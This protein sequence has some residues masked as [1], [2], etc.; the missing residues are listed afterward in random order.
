MGNVITT[1][2]SYMFGTGPPAVQTNGMSASAEP[3]SNDTVWTCYRCTYAYNAV[4]SVECE[5]CQLPRIAEGDRIKVSSAEWQCPLCTLVNKTSTTT[6]T[7]CGKMT[8]T[9]I[10]PPASTI[11][12]APALAPARS[13]RPNA[14]AASSSNS[15]N[16]RRAPPKSDARTSDERI[17]GRL[18]RHQ[19]MLT[20]EKNWEVELATALEKY[21]SV[22][23]FCLQNREPV[24]IHRYI[25]PIRPLWV[26]YDIET[27]RTY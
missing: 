21:R 11:G 25:R 3:P 8:F 20:G 5:Q 17:L 15:A 16:G 14:A 22:V 19:N 27:L 12:P 18:D 9:A 13:Q 4:S 10:R 24:C 6:C 2:D 26:T 1:V 7:G 23:S